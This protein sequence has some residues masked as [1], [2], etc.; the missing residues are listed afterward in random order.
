MA[1]RKIITIINEKCTGCGLC[2][3][4]CP[5]GAIKII[6]G[7]ARL[8][9][10]LFCDG[11][12]A[13][14]GHCPQGA[15]IVEEREAVP[16]DERT[17]MGNIVKQGENTIREH[18]LHLKSHNETGYLGT[19]LAYLA[20]NHLRIPL[21]DLPEEKVAGTPD[22][23]DSNAGGV[24]ASEL[25][26][27]PVQ[28]HLVSPDAP[29]FRK[30][31]V[32]LAADCT[33]FALGD[34]H[35]KHLKGKALAVACPKLDHGQDIYREKLTALVDSAGINTL[36]VLTMQVPCC[37]GL[38]VLAKNAVTSAKRKIPVKSVVV[39]LKGDLLSEEWV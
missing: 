31:D 10:D 38:L 8:L 26:Q 13:C 12:G 19:A 21:E 35:T 20:E 2:I 15:I 5:E 18:L 25:R 28:L 32:L 3:P 17:V 39:G 24:Q 4:T 6:D 34:F 11:L 7:K 1:K 36:T 29:Y 16:Y 14:L 27:W 37:S 30:A 9:G 22:F 33:A 23:S